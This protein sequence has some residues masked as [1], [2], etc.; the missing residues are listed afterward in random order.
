MTN[1]NISEELFDSYVWW[2]EIGVI[3]GA[4][5]GYIFIL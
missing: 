3:L 2:A 5:I 1:I 4:R